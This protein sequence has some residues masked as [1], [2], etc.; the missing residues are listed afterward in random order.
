[1]TKADVLSIEGQK[2]GIV[3]LPEQFNKPIRLDLIRRAVFSIQS[4][5]YQ[6]YGADPLAGTRQGQATPKRRKKFGTTYGYGVSRV[7]RKRF[8]R[9]GSRFG[10]QAAFVASAIKGR[11]AFPPKIEKVFAEKINRKERRKAICSA[12]SAAKSYVIEDKFEGLKKSKEVVIVLNKIGLKK[13]L[14]RTKQKKVRAGK[15]T[16]RGR[17]YKRKVGP[18]IVAEKKCSL[19]KSAANVPGIAIVEVKNLNAELLAPGMNAG[20]ITIWTQSAIEKL[21]KERLF[22]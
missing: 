7:R 22:S 2:I 11:R 13:E 18:L 14:E 15:G 8:W 19:L 20:R 10:W 9:R 3:E 1:M 21:A 4:H 5:N 6:P 12:I 17:K 16:M